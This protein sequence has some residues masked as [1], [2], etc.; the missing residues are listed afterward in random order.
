MAWRD[1]DDYSHK[2]EAPRNFD[3]PTRDRRCT[4]VLC[5][6]LLVASWAGMSAIG[7]YAVTEGDPRLVLYPL[8]YDGNICGTDFGP[9]NMTDFPNLLYINHFTGGVCVKECPNLEN[10]TE[11]GLTDVRTL[12]TYDGIFQVDG[13]ELDAD[14]IEVGD[15]SMSDD[16]KSCTQD[17]CFPN[18]SV[19][20]S[21]MTPGIAK[22]WSFAYYATT[23]YELLF[24][25]YTSTQ[26]ERR[27]AELVGDNST[28]IVEAGFVEDAFDFTNKLFA[29]VFVARKYVLGLGFGL[30]MGVSLVYIF[31]MRLP[32]LLAVV[33]WGSILTTIALCFGGGYYAYT[34]MLM[35]KENDSVDQ[36]YVTMTTWF[37]VFLFGLGG[38][39]LI[40]GCCLRNSIG[41]AIRCTKEAGKAVNSMT[42]I[43]LVPILQSIGLL[44]FLIPFVYYAIH[45]ASLGEITTEEFAVGPELTGVSDGQT[46]IS[47][48]VFEFD[49]VTEYMGWF[50]L[51][52]L[53]WTGNFIIAMGDVSNLNLIHHFT[54]LTLV[55]FIFKMVVA[56]SVS[57]WYFT[58]NK[59]KIGSWTVIGSIIDVSWYHAGTAAF[60]SLLVAIVQLIRAILMRLQKYA[61]KLDNKVGQCIL[62]CCQC[63]FWFLE[64]VIKYVNKNA[65]IQTAIFSTS[66]CKSCRES[67]A[68]IFR[69]P[70]RVSA[71]AYV[72][73]AVL[74]I[75]KLFISSIVTVVGYYVIAED[76]GDHLHTVAGPLGVIFVI[77]YF[78]SDIFMD[79]LSMGISTVLHCFIA[80]E[81]MFDE[82][83]RYTD[84]SLKNYVDHYGGEK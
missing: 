26:A 51:F 76:I 75:G 71:I 48:R 78:I 69:N 59:W 44:V 30:S 10:V 53:F 31:L 43:L 55:C 38:V 22:G 64:C 46:E 19:E 15:Y 37:S 21:W 41:D 18:D 35:W 16:A 32:G 39:L 79:V 40:A 62:S 2:L 66:F 80:D 54:T 72:S 52:C 67:F 84:R 4:D 63:C 9:S 27:L 8:D 50:L 12:V 81:E 33:V 56:V 6:L 29:D 14:F 70:G 68:L 11:D 45:L 61:K 28:H 5:L 58:K 24:R 7:Y 73:G 1:D 57:K 49:D 82:N 34:R 60:G 77:S 36:Q 25:C 13:A 74:I 20:L 42:L 17:T 23:T 65:Y 83:N 3:G 47:F